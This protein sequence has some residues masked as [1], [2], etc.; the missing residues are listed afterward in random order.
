MV[1]RSALLRVACSGILGIAASATTV[2][3][4]AEGLEE[5]IVTAQKRAQSLQE[6]PVAVSAYSDK[7]RDLVGIS[8]VQ[9]I[10]NFTP[11]ILYTSSADRMYMRGIGRQSNNLSTSPGVA[12][13]GDGFYNSSNHE[14]DATQMFTERVEVLRG[15]QGTL[16]GRNSDGGALNVVTKRPKDEF[17]AEVRLGGGS[18]DG[19]HGEGYVTGPITDWL[20]FM[21]GGGQYV[22]QKGYIDNQIGPDSWDEYGRRDNKVG[23][24][25]FSG[26]IGSGVDFWVKYRHTEW[27]EGN[28]SFVTQ[29]PYVTRTVCTPGPLLPPVPPATTSTP[30]NCSPS[31]VAAGSLGPSALY[32]TGLGYTRGSDNIVRPNPAFDLRPSVV[33]YTTPN[34]GVTDLRASNHNTQQFDT[35]NPD[36]TVVL[37]VVGHLPFADLKYLGGWHEYNYYQQTD[38]D[39]SNRDS[40]VYTPRSGI[41][42]VTISSVVF[43]K[44][45]EN[46]HYY[47]NELNLISTGDGPMKW[48]LG[49]YQYDEH[50]EQPTETDNPNQIQL[51]T[52]IYPVAPFAAAAPNP[53]GV[54]QATDAFM[55][56]TS[57]AGFG[58][59]DYAI[60]DQWTATIGARYTRD[61]K[62]GQ[63]YARR[64]SWN[65]TPTGAATAALDISGLPS[66]FGGFVFPTTG[67]GA[68][69]AGPGVPL[70]D[71]SGLYTRKLENENHAT[72]GTAG[73]EWHPQPGMN[74]Y[75]KYTR[76][77]KDGSVSAGAF[78]QYPYADPEFVNAYE[79]GWKQDF[80]NRFNANVA[81]FFNDIKG[82]QIPLTVINPGAPVITQTFNLNAQ[83]AGVELETNWQATDNLAF[84][85]NY[86]YLDAHVV[87]KKNCFTDSLDA[88]G[89][90][91]VDPCYTSTGAVSGHIV[92][93]NQ[94][95][96][97]PK[98]RVAFNGRYTFNFAPGGLTFSANYIWR[99]GRYST[100]FRRPETHS[101]SFDQVDL[102]AIWVDSS[103]RYSI[104][105][106]VRNAFD[107]DGYDG[108]VAAV[109]TD[110][111]SRSV[112][113]T[114]PREWGAELQYRFGST[115]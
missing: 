61:K 88:S 24:V 96:G 92:D 20:K 109:T 21:V 105:G 40:Y 112:S 50:Y 53:N 10:V 72:T 64:V 60:N 56:N 80:N 49:L 47:S 38:F 26:N 83:S 93:G 73:F 12:S 52:P 15:P 87:D 70:N 7:V 35:L 81:V 2:A 85:F 65:P 48:V 42:P 76:G 89:I 44:Y 37:E 29:T 75:F 41:N 45:A 1:K 103:N 67:T 25:Q 5:V 36:N 3:W 114:N 107:T 82:M 111:I 32:N 57:I 94:L 43:S 106:Y 23:L 14:A 8:T 74:G 33:P 30:T 102:R 91:G 6:V 99:E 90:I 27:D 66:G 63:E 16:Y 59:I 11:G 104:I 78:A 62:Y 31:L 22:Q 68:S 19:Y 108:T 58:Q 95:P 84:L 39:N 9:D 4:A 113:L 51:R 13:Y 101:P 110:G 97:S 55:T 69:P 86:A 115:K 77:Y 79:L 71:G 28:G 17:G 18:Y 100:I 98:N 34:P 46:K 54:F